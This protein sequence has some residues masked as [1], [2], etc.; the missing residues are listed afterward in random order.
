MLYLDAAVTPGLSFSNATIM[1]PAGQTAFAWQRHGGSQCAK[2]PEN[3]SP[4]NENLPLHPPM[5]VDCGA[6]GGTITAISFASYGLP[7]G[8][9]GN[10]GQSCRSILLFC[11]FADSSFS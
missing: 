5:V 2:A 6:L 11:V 3:Q 4:V 10:F 7:V 1:T 8:Y 9:C